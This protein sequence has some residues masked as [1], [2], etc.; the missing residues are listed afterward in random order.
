MPRDSESLSLATTLFESLQRLAER[1]RRANTA[2]AREQ[3]GSLS[4]D[5][6]KVRLMALNGRVA[7]ITMR[8]TTD[9]VGSKTVQCYSSPASFPE[10]HV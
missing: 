8:C 7:I 6:G 3:D 2:W 1:S 10:T 4:A 5:D 9:S